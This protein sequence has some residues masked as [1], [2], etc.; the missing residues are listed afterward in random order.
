MFILHNLK[1]K[2]PLKIKK[3]NERYSLELND[4]FV[5]QEANEKPLENKILL[6]ETD[7]KYNLRNIKNVEYCKFFDLTTKIIQKDVEDIKPVSFHELHMLHGSK[8]A[9][10]ILSKMDKTDNGLDIERLSFAKYSGDEQIIPT[11]NKEAASVNHIYRLSVMFNKKLVKELRKYKFSH[12]SERTKDYAYKESR[13]AHFIILDTLLYILQKKFIP[14]KLPYG[15]LS[16]DILNET[17][18]KKSEDKYLERG[19]FRRYEVFEKYKLIAMACIMLLVINNYELNI[20]HLPQ[21]G[22]ENDEIKKIFQL[23]GC[24]WDKNQIKLVKMPTTKVRVKKRNRK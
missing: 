18:F 4:G 21:L 5:I 3:I 16:H 15:D 12:R 7:D 2:I 10:K 13:K 6:V 8:K 14:E 11:F 9:K 22:I 1:S 23:L 17:L 19:K 20:S 24:K